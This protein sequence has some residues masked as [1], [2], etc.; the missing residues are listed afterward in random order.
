V[1]LVALAVGAWY[2]E[3][4]FVRVPVAAL[5]GTLSG[6]LLLALMMLL[7]VLASSQRVGGVL[8]LAVLFPLM[9][10]GGSFFPF[11]SM[12]AWMVAVGQRTPNG[13]SVSVLRAIVRGEAGA[14]A[15]AT[16][17]LVLLAGIAL[18]FAAVAWRMRAGFARGG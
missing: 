16:G 8:T 10:L 7:Q 3:V 17:S 13:W 5:W 2:F 11:E 9:M 1:C 18:L 12:P 4:P 15:L 14:G 6:A